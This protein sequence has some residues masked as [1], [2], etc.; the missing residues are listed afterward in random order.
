MNDPKDSVT[1]SFWSQRDGEWRRGPSDSTPTREAEA[2]WQGEVRE[3]AESYLSADFEGIAIVTDDDE[4][5]SVLDVFSVSYEVPE[6][7]RPE[8]VIE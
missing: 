7:P 5:S 8:L 1:V 6:A 4:A 3:V 2:G